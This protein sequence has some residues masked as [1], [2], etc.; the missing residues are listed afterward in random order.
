MPRGLLIDVILVNAYVP[1]RMPD[2]EAAAV[3]R[4]L[5]GPRFMDRLRRAV[6]AVAGQHAPL[7]KVRFTLT[8]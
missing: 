7:A 3:R 2:A 6:R 4:M 8:R 1:S 5:R